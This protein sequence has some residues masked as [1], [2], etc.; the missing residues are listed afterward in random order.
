VDLSEGYH[1]VTVVVYDRAGNAAVSFVEFYVDVSPP[2]IVIISPENGAYLNSG[3]IEVHWQ[4]EDLSGIAYYEVRIDDGDWIYVGL[5]CTYIVRDLPDGSH[6]I[7][8]RATDALG[9]SSERTVVFTVD[10]TAPEL[11]LVY[12]EN[13]TEF[14]IEG[15]DIWVNITWTGNDNIELDHFEVSVDDGPWWN[16]GL[17]TS[18]RVLLSIGNHTIRIRAYD[19][20]NNYAEIRVIISVRGKGFITIPKDALLAIGG[21]SLV[22][23]LSLIVGLRRRKKRYFRAAW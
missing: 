3:T 10:T 13:N 14:V 8:V 4:G 7:S 18:R 12:P 22:I 23:T 15:L 11:S 1:N 16:V 6:L 9:F 5:N 19:K 21:L 17:N 2:Y 20:A